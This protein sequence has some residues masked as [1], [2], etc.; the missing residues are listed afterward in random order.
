M[1]S[2]GI[3]P[4]AGGSAIPLVAAHAPG[5]IAS[6]ISRASAGNRRTVGEDGISNVAG[7]WRRRERSLRS[8]FVGRTR[9]AA[10]GPFCRPAFFGDAD[11]NRAEDRRSRV[12][13]SRYPTQAGPI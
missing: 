13:G 7:G 2:I 3:V 12:G 1:K 10:A 6:A 8:G 9:V 5:A 4:I 11:C